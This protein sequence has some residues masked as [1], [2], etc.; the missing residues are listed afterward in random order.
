M[1]GNVSNDNGADGIR[2]SDDATNTTVTTNSIAGN[3]TQ[4]IEIESDANR[5]TGH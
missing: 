3:R 1:G 5:I 2:L 4:G